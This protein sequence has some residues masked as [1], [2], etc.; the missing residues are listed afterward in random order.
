[1]SFLDNPQKNMIYNAV[2]IK[3]DFSADLQLLTAVLKELQNKQKNV[4]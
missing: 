1:L 4:L 2:M 3:E